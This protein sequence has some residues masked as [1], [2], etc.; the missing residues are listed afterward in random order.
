VPRLGLGLGLPVLRGQS[1]WP[2]ET[3]VFDGGTIEAYSGADPNDA[4]DLLASGSMPAKAF[5]PWSGQ[6]GTRSR[7]FLLTVAKNGAVGGLL[8]R[9]SD[10][11]PLAWIDVV[12]G[13][14]VGDTV[15]LDDID[16]IIGDRISAAIDWDSMPHAISTAGYTLIS[17]RPFSV[18]GDHG[19]DTGEGSPAP[20]NSIEG[21]FSEFQ[22]VSDARSRV[23]RPLTGRMRFATGFVDGVSPATAYLDLN[24]ASLYKWLYVRYFF[25]ISA[26]WYGHPTGT[27]KIFFYCAS[28]GVGGRIFDRLWGVGTADLEYRLALQNVDPL[29]SRTHLAANIGGPIIIPRGHQYK[30]KI[31]VLLGLNTAGSLNGTVKAAINGVLR[32]NYTDVGVLQTGES[33]AVWG[34]NAVKWDPIY[35]GGGGSTV[36]AEMDQRIDNHTTYAKV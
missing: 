22:I 15:G 19:L 9:G 6:L 26:N 28:A 35:G 34:S 4:G 24:A 25:S 36:P 14:A 8:L 1:G 23:T 11:T 32:I 31:E 18:K 2:S 20:W 7:T 33:A 21:I 29:E 27:N 3:S 17:D 13:A 10:T 5:G 12:E 16:V 30:T